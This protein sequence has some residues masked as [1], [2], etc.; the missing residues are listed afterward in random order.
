[1]FK[2]ECVYI[3]HFDVA[4]S[5]AEHYVGCTRDI[6]ARL[7]AHAHGAGS[8]L[9]RV[10]N[11]RGISWRLGALGM[12]SHIGMRRMERHLKNQ[13]NTR[14]YCEVCNPDGAMKIPGTTPYPLALVPFKDAESFRC[15]ENAA[16]NGAVFRFTDEKDTRRVT[17]QILTLWKADRDALGFVPMGGENGIEVEMRKGNVL[18]TEIEGDILGYV[19]FTANVAR[20]VVTIQQCCVRD[21]ARLYGFGRQMVD[22]VDAIGNWKKI[23]ARVKEQLAA[24][25]FW[26][27]IGFTVDEEH[28]HETSGNLIV[29][30]VRI[31]DESNGQRME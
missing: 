14:R 3:L 26:Q 29:E 11:E 27:A 13:K 24:N 31:K 22:M 21:D 25:H 20:D 19:Y 5:H 8:N 10:L 15:I 28:I 16:K 2:R 23:Q 18:V 9:C 1:M 17:D 4:L 7:G 30:Y 12:C 6:M